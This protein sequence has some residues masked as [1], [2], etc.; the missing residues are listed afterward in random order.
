MLA[1]VKGGG[2]AISRGGGVYNLFGSCNTLFMQ[3]KQCNLCF[4]HKLLIDFPSRAG[5]PTGGKCKRCLAE[6]K[7]AN[8]GKKR[9]RNY[10]AELTAAEK[11][12]IVSL[13][14]AGRTLK[15]VAA[16]FSVTRE[17]IRKQLRT[18]NVPYL[19]QEEVVSRNDR[20]NKVNTKKQLDQLEQETGKTLLERRKEAAARKRK[21]V[22]DV[23]FAAL[24]G[25]SCVDCGESDLL[26]LQFDHREPEKKERDI[27][28]C[29]TVTSVLK[30]LPKC[31][32]VCANCHARR[33]QRMFGSWRLAYIQAANEASIGI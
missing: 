14:A 20:I 11:T 19:S 10:R 25:K 15:E 33:T 13:F 21:R 5:K 28:D 8:E 2:L 17:T 12:E 32:I 4:E 23:I 29:S 30:E 27:S 16:V 7:L 6:R 31:D 9:K 22:T 24:T 26:V 1:G 3:T 18:A